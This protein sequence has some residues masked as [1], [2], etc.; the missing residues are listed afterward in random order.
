L[1][2]VDALL[3]GLIDYAGLFPPAGLDM[4]AAVE[5]YAAYRASS[6]SAALARFIVPLGRLA[7]LEEIAADL[8]PNGTS[9]DQWRL[10]VLLSGDTSTVAH[11]INAFNARHDFGATSG[12]AVIDA[13]ELKAIKSEEIERAQ[14][15]LPRTLT[16]YFEIPV[17]NDV[18]SLMKTLARVGARAKI[19][20]GGVTADAFPASF[21]IVG[22][23][24]AALRNSVR[25]KATAGLHHPITGRY[26]LT[27]ESASAIGRMYGFVNLFLAAALLHAGTQEGTVQSVL[28]ESDASQFSITET[29]IS[30]RDITASADELQRS[31]EDFAISFGS[32]SFRE[33]VDEIEN[34][35]HDANLKNH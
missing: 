9:R 24:A 10:S 22:F 15:A 5:N 35:T 25:F 31:R 3:S 29:T 17:A 33:P 34:L 19:R 26:P 30:W 12:H 11:T 14:A 16:T 20:T 13:V 8:L 7:E 1:R 32:C 6:D 28:D 18:T 2:S 27:Y 4:R 23:M 21:E